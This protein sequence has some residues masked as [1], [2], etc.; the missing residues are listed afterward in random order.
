LTVTGTSAEAGDD[1]QVGRGKQSQWAY[2]PLPTDDF[3]SR[4][5]AKNPV[6]HVR[7]G[8]QHNDPNSSPNASF[9]RV[10]RSPP[11]LLLHGQPNRENPLMTRKSSAWEIWGVPA[12]KVESEVKAV[13]D[14]VLGSWKQIRDG[15][16]ERKWQ[17]Y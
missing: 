8:L 13:V 6:S 5:L 9:E 1:G 17:I 12:A 2:H 3:G 11:S 10:P 4:L 16:V 7:Q 15:F 14:E